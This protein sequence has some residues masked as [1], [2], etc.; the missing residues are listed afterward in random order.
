MIKLKPHQTQVVKYMKESNNRGIILYHGLGS[1][2]TITSIAISKL[3]SNNV[4]IIVP[5]SMRTQWIPELERMEVDIKKYQVISYEKL[6]SMVELKTITSFEDMVVIV[7]EAHRIRSSTG[8]ISTTI[9]KQ[10]QTAEKVILLTGTPMVNNPVDMS[11][12]INA[13]QGSD[14]LPTNEKLFK[15]K[16]YVPKSSKL[17]KIG[18]KC[19]LYSIVTCDNKGSI[20]KEKLCK[21]HYVKNAKRIKVKLVPQDLNG[22]IMKDWK[23]IQDKRINETR[24]IAKLSILKPNVLE[25]SKFV[26]NLISYYKPKKNHDFPETTIKRIKVGMSPEQN[27]LYKKAE[28][29][30]NR[31]DLNLL[32]KGIEITRKSAAMNA[33]LNVTRQ[34]SNTWEGNEDTPKLK[35]ILEMIKKNP[36]PAL[37]YSNWIGN[38]IKPLGSMLLK[39]NISYLEFTG[40]LTESKKKREVLDYNSN[41]I[42]VLLL[43]SSGGEGLDLKNTRQ[44][45]IM[46]PHWNDAKISQV[47]GRGIRYKSHET[48]PI[49]DRNVSVFHWISTPLNTK[50]IGTDEYLYNISEKKL[51]EMELF[52]DTSIKNSIENDLPIKKKTKKIIKTKN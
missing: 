22:L 33:F 10:L 52:L 46:E 19:K 18:E 5:A 27:K 34:I 30:V 44:I 6:L 3:Y 49:K 1:G 20:Y 38:G 43:S 14:I 24:A 23:K 45:H 21:Y 12:L 8:K 36:K 35:K 17:G 7:D 39:Q 9:V 16:F 37:V 31:E 40:S 41:K 26:K 25:Y 11:P 4:L 50:D 29:G 47:I 15:E 2:K 28:K 13:I 48:L 51:E 42:D 32:K